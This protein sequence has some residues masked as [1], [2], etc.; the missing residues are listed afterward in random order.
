[1]LDSISYQVKLLGSRDTPNRSKILSRRKD[2]PSSHKQEMLTSSYN[3]I[4]ILLSGRLV[5]F[6]DKLCG[7]WK[8]IPNIVFR[9]ILTY[10]I[11]IMMIQ[12]YVPCPARKTYSF[13]KNIATGS[14]AVSTLIVSLLSQNTSE[15]K[16]QSSMALRYDS[17][18]P[19]FNEVDG[20]EVCFNSNCTMDPSIL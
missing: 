4:A 19:R 6:V 12:R 13:K 15:S 1:M 5:T 10:K 20:V 2:W 18:R 17:W 16:V 14:K 11:V 9:H 8:I 3:H 7:V